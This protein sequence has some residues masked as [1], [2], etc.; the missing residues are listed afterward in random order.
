M[1]E[2]RLYQNSVTFVWVDVFQAFQSLSHEDKKV[3]VCYVCLEDIDSGQVLDM[4]CY[5]KFQICF[6]I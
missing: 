4:F 2:F 3:V 1:S 6:D 5:L